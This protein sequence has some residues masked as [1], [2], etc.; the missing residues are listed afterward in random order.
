[1]P[2]PTSLTL[3]PT[4]PPPTP[5]PLAETV[6]GVGVSDAGE[7][8]VGGGSVVGS[9][10]GASM[11]GGSEKAAILGGSAK[12]AAGAPE[13]CVGVSEM[14]NE[15][16]VGEVA[17]RTGEAGKAAADPGKATEAPNGRLAA[18]WPSGGSSAFVLPMPSLVLWR[19]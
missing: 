2:P 7:G 11:L 5:R 16:L 1:M 4:I 18:D 3:L 6:G 14:A 13:R 12:V 15:G 8:A 17:S 10:G 19:A 9:R